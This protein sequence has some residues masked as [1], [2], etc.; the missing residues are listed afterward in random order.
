MQK[1]NIV[2]GFEVI[3]NFSDD[4]IHPNK[5]LNQPREQKSDRK[6]SNQ[7]RKQDE[8]TI[9]KEQKNKI[10]QQ[11]QSL[12]NSQNIEQDEEID[13]TEYLHK[14]IPKIYTITF[15]QTGKTVAIGTEEGLRIQSS[16]S[17][18]VGMSNKK[19]IMEKEKNIF[20]NGIKL[21]SLMFDTYICALV[22]D[23]KN[24]EYPDSRVYIWDQKNC[25]IIGQYEFYSPILQI[26]YMREFL[27]VAS[28]QRLVLYDIVQKKPLKYI[29]DI[30]SP[31]KFVA[32]QRYD[33]FTF[34][35]LAKNK[36]MIIA[37]NVWYDN[38]VQ[39]DFNQEIGA[40]T[41]QSQEQRDVEIS[42]MVLS[43]DGSL[44]AACEK[45]SN[46]IKIFD[47]ERGKLKCTLYR[48]KFPKIITDMQF[49][50]DL[51]AFGLIS[52][53]E[54]KSEDVGTIHIYDISIISQLNK[55]PNRIPITR[56]QNIISQQ[57]NFDILKKYSYASKDTKFQGPLIQFD[58]Q[59]S[60]QFTIYSESDY[61]ITQE[62]NLT[63]DEPKKRLTD[64]QKQDGWIDPIQDK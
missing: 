36:G 21:V 26:C 25:Q 54:Q 53:Y 40:S 11:Q 18:N 51:T 17:L 44:L 20:F 12:E 3:D 33:T 41:P 39:I 27:L 13:D 30:S 29:L 2:E 57:F 24:K 56:L 34:C 55:E 19:Y 61:T 48:G 43:H 4:E 47:T 8:N 6:S 45:G 58:P 60:N 38:P 35:Y 42:N 62:Y 31:Q 28:E 15:S 5:Q 1:Q 59:G 46:I 63:S 37:T 16:E 23:N 49:K 64:N 50:K 52:T 9:K 22:T 32:S 7:Q 14:N 10:E